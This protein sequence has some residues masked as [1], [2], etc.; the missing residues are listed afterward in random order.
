[1]QALLI[2]AGRDRNGNPRKLY[3]VLIPGKA[4]Q[5]FDIGYEGSGALPLG[6]RDLADNPI[7]INVTAKEYQRILKECGYGN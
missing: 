6:W 3:L 5:A 2:N 7:Q 4:P 1:M